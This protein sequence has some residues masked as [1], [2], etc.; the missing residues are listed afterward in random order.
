MEDREKKIREYWEE[1][2][3]FKKAED[4]PHLP[5]MN[6]YFMNKLIQLG[7]LSKNRLEDGV[8]YHGNYRNSNLGKW[9]DKDQKFYLWRW[10]FGW[11]PDDCNHF[12]DDDA[13]ALFVPLRKATEEEIKAENNNEGKDPIWKNV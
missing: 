2:K 1:L 9:S 11:R 5:H 8:W 3:P 12:E 6:H 4:V 10:K 13:F 7:A